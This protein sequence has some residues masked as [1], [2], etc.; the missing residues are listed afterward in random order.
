M[1]LL[2]EQKET[3]PDLA[4]GYESLKDVMAREI[5][6]NA[7]SVHV[8]HN[9]G[10][11]K[12]TLA[13]V[14]DKNVN[15][16]PC[17]L[18]LNNLPKDQKGVLYQNKFLVLCN[19]MPVFSGHFTIA[20]LIHQPQSITEHIDIFL[21][22]MSDFGSHWSILYNGPRC[23]ASA[24]DHLHFQAIPS[25]MMPIEKEIMDEKRRIQT[26]RID[27]VK[28]S[29]AE[30]LG[31]EL[32]IIEG[33]DP[34]GMTDVFK[35]IVAELK[36]VFNTDNEPMMNIIGSHDGQTWRAIVFPRAK[37]RPDVFFREGDARV[38][39]SPAVIEMGGVLV[40]PVERDFERL[41]ASTVEGIFGE[42]SL[43]GEIVRGIVEVINHRYNQE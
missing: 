36:K 3:W 37:H 24:P 15:E 28:V 17:F 29:R 18:C 22:L 41:D 32:I 19:P 13:N 21:Q 35:Q 14:G 38:A 1:E 27:G 39:I 33:N 34:V 2:S 4:Q 31:R 12:S 5:I 10:R 43:K 7:F 26:V 30:D 20:H 23:G 9:P 8:Q 25:G 11:I 40:A 16:R 6:C 42:V